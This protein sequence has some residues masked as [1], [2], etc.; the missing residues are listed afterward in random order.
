MK[1]YYPFAKNKSKQIVVTQRFGQNLNTY[2]AEAGKLGHNGEDLWEGGYLEP[3]YAPVTGILYSTINKNNPDLMQYR[4]IYILVDEPENG[5]AYEVSLGHLM[6]IFVD[7][8]MNIQVGTPVGTMGNTGDVASGGVKVTAAMKA[9]GSGAGAHV[10]FQVRLLK[11]VDKK[12]KN[13]TYIQTANGY[14]KK[15]TAILK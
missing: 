10:H 6:D 9:N 15:T 1:L 8:E 12:E 14:Y 7:P 3:L 11:K 5:L 13:K 4:A 2:Y